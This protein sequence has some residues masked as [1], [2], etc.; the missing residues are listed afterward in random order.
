MNISLLSNDAG[1]TGLGAGTSSRDL[2]LRMTKLIWVT[3]EQ[4]ARRT[5]A[6]CSTLVQ[7]SSPSTGSFCL[8]TCIKEALT[9]ALSHTCLAVCASRYTV[10]RPLVLPLRS[11]SFVGAPVPLLKCTGFPDH[12][13][14]LGPQDVHTHTHCLPKLLRCYTRI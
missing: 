5:N 4:T 3:P 9:L 8:F 10:E 11:R 1:Y 13:L 6:V 2:V 7:I 12:Y 14:V